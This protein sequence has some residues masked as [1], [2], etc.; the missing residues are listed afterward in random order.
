MSSSETMI[1]I[2]GIAK[3]YTIRHHQEHHVTLAEQTI[4]FFK[5]PRQ[6]VEKEQFWALEN[7]DLD[8]QRGEVLGVIGRNGAGKSTLLKVLSRITPPTRGE[9]RLHGR[10]GSLLEVGTGFHPELTGRENIYLNGSILGMRKKEIDRQFEAIIDFAGVEHFLDTPVK[11]YSSGMYVRLAFAVA[12]H[13]ET[14]I[15]LVDEV[16]SV[17]DADFQKRCLGK[18]EEVASYGR[19]VL[20]VS[21]NMH[22]VGTTCTSAVQLAGGR[23][24]MV[25]D[26]DEVV[27]NYLATAESVLEEH[28]LPDEKTRGGSGEVRVT[29]VR[30]TQAAFLPDETKR[31]VVE[32]AK[33][34]DTEP[35]FWISI[36]L[37]DERGVEI[38]QCDSRAVGFWPKLDGEGRAR[39][40]F[41]IAGPWLKPGRHWL[42]LYV[43]AMGIVDHVTEACYFDVSPLLPY[44]EPVGSDAT[45]HGVVL[46]DFSYVPDHA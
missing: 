8:V 37:K 6:R 3:A 17:G 42:D 20:F 9:I 28:G 27:A 2:R 44:P 41:E 35:Q 34:V 21:H 13:L 45:A 29:A 15:L 32:L 26:T 38:A 14:E 39:F 22:A 12:A 31:F 18:M 16:L 43:C 4:A 19:T 10:I 36:H 7:I 24:V 46:A 23:V 30:P 40:E 11:R 33:R 1:S 5:N 25:G